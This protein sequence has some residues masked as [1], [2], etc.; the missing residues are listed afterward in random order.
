MD[1]LYR[2][3]LRLSR[4]WLLPTSRS[5]PEASALIADTNNQALASKG[6]GAFSCS[7]MRAQLQ[8]AS[9]AFIPRMPRPHARHAPGGGLNLNFDIAC[10][11]GHTALRCSKHHELA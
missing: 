3:R 4:L 9:P 6:A 5:S 2:R 8:A 1:C 10:R 11:F 7:P